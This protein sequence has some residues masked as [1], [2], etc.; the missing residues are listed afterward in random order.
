MNT[1]DLDKMRSNLF[2][3]PLAFERSR[4]IQR[5]EFLKKAGDDYYYFK[6]REYV[7]KNI[8][9]RHES[10][11]KWPWEHSFLKPIEIK[12]PIETFRMEMPTKPLM[13][14]SNLFSKEQDFGLIKCWCGK[15]LGHSGSC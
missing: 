5:S 6:S 7:N 3:A 8:F 13:F 12:L 10:E 14:P 1:D 11:K 9:G 2:W 15:L 4:D